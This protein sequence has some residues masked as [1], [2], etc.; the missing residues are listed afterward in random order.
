MRHT[1]MM[2]IVTIVMTTTPM[3]IMVT[4]IVIMAR[5][6][7][8][9]RSYELRQSR[10][11]HVGKQ[12]GV[13]KEDGRV[14]QELST[15]MKKEDSRSPSRASRASRVSRS[16]HDLSCVSTAASRAR[17]RATASYKRKSR[18]EVEG[19]RSTTLMHTHAHTHVQSALMIPGEKQANGD[20]DGRARHHKV[21][22]EHRSK[23]SGGLERSFEQGELA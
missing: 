21:T 9:G 5:G 15:S 4:M 1:A 18:V 12:L 13:R 23:Y 3:I 19:G 6:G 11:G 22:T 8:A 17:E 7:A 2:I 10:A 14:R 16:V 20:A